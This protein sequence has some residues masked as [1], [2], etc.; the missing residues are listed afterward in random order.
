MRRYCLDSNVFIEAYR[1]YYS[2]DLVPVFWDWLDKQIKGNAIF[3]CENVFHEIGDL[4]D[5]LGEWFKERKSTS[6][7]TPIS[8]S[9]IKVY[10][11]IADHVQRK[12]KFEHAKIFLEGADGWVIA[13]AKV[14]NAIVVTNER[15]AGLNAYKVKIPNICDDFDVEV[16]KPIEMMRALG[17][18]FT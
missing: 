5:E 11:A 7:N 13:M 3:C 15:H 18:K 6:I 8:D 2:M 10:S 4:D 9:I 17:A 16:I 14:E 12:Y 1:G